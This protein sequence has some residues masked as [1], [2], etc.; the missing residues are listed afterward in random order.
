MKMYYYIFKKRDRTSFLGEWSCIKTGWSQFASMPVPWRKA[1]IHQK[2]L[3]PRL[4]QW[5]STERAGLRYKFHGS[6]NDQNSSTSACSKLDTCHVARSIV[7]LCRWLMGTA[8]SGTWASSAVC[9]ACALGP[10]RRGPHAAT[11]R[12]TWVSLADE[13]RK[14]EI[15]RRTC[16]VLGN[17]V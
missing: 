4:N 5:I 11:A 15:L 13:H 10:G 14:Q 2:Q 16:K 8:F 7:R 6:K 3:D 1:E 9:T 12:E 17:L